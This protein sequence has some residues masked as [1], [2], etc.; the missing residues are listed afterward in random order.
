MD[1]ARNT[2]YGSLLQALR[3]R[4]DQVRG[5]RLRCRPADLE[6]WAQILYPRKCGWGLLLICWQRRSEVPQSRKHACFG[7]VGLASAAG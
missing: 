3:Q 2:L 5:Q 6:P 7:A 4:L 1:D